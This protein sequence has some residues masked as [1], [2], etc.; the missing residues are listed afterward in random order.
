MN[1]LDKFKLFNA[2][3][4]HN[5]VFGPSKDKV[6]WLSCTITEC[7]N[8]IQ[9]VVYD[10]PQ[11]KSDNKNICPTC[12]ENNRRGRLLMKLKWME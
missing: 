8:H 1:D 12:E 5:L 3:M 6:M 9:H 7:D 2:E 4:E 10:D 11:I